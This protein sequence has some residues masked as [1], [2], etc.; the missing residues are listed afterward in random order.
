[1]NKIKNK[2]KRS[3]YYVLTSGF[4]LITLFNVILFSNYIED[5]LLNN[6][7]LGKV[8]VVFFMIIYFTEILESDSIL[9]IKNSL[10]FWIAFGVF[11][12]NLTFLPAFTLF[13]YTSVFGAFQFI[14]L[15]L[16]VI[17]HACFITGFIMSKK[18]FN[19]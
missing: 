10:Y 2:F 15:G 13:K 19:T 18:E 4:V 8:I 7:I 5:L 1:L 12:Y 9:N 11:L 14:T 3:I 16:N 17:M 6:I